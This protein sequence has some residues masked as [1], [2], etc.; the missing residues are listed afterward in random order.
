MT[1]DAPG[2]NGD[3]P[4]EGQVEDKIHRVEGRV[5][6]REDREAIR[7]AAEVLGMST[8]RFVGLAALER[9]TGKSLELAR[10]ENI[11]AIQEYVEATSR[12]L[13]R[14]LKAVRREMAQF[15]ATAAGQHDESHARLARGL[16][17]I[18]E[19]RRML[20]ASLAGHARTQELLTGNETLV[21]EQV[22][23]NGELLD[24]LTAERCGVGGCAAMEGRL[25]RLL[26]LVE[27]IVAGGKEGA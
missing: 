22:Q 4:A 17:G 16:D 26:E 12:E 14:E 23:R 18:E 1:D 20:D 2:K 19:T 9:A 3:P 10:L 6:R 7:A 13:I 5:P 27:R 15:S 24:R 11:L 25:A 8:W 21:A